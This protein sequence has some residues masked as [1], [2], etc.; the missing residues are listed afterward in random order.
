MRTGIRI[1]IWTVVSAA[2]L[3]LHVAAF[4]GLGN[5]GR[6][7]SSKP[8]KRST[9]VEME[10]APKAPPPPPPV[11][12]PTPAR[13]RTKAPRLAMAR[14]VRANNPAPPPAV[15]PP[16]PAETIADFSG[17]TLTNDGPGPGWSSATGNGEAMRGPVGRAGAR[18][19]GRNVDGAPADGTPVVGLGNLSQPPEPPNLA[20]ALE[21]L[22]PAGARQKGVGGTA[23]VRLRVMP[24]GTVRELMVMAESVTGF[25][26]ACKQ[27]LR[28]SR[29]TPPLD[30]GGQAVSTHVQYT[31]RFEV[32]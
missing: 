3:G 28:G 29:W 2:S 25:G 15:A 11:A 7:D 4:G 6:P 31:C 1:T 30:R 21:R 8:R 10:V 14:P 26:E 19:T 22:Y 32:R 18:V 9:T 23:K 13:A 12:E 16:P 20:S 24:D 27:T 17:T 5:V